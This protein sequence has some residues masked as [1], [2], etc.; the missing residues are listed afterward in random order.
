MNDLKMTAQ[1]VRKD[2]D[3]RQFFTVNENYRSL[4]IFLRDRV[5][6]FFASGYLRYLLFDALART[7]KKATLLRA[8]SSL[9]LRIFITRC[10]AFILAPRNLLRPLSYLRKCVSLFRQGGGN[11]A[12]DPRQ[13]LAAPLSPR[14]H[15]HLRRQLTRN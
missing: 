13:S 2:N 5:E 11:L 6:D 9:L 12:H 8:T 14:V 7:A 1:K 10:F 4:C 15:T 3:R